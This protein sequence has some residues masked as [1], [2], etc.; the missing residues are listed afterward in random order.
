[1]PSN[2]GEINIRQ[3]VLVFEKKRAKLEYGRILQKEDLEN[4]SRKRISRE[5][6][7]N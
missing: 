5:K 6:Q 3:I 7:H 1:M 2:V 4:R